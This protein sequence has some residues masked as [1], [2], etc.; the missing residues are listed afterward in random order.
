MATTDFLNALGVGS[1]FSSKEVITA[2]VDA[3]KVPTQENKQQDRSHRSQN[4]RAWCSKSELNT[5]KES[6]AKLKDATD[7]DSFSI[8][9]SQATALTVTAGAGASA[10]NHS[11]TVSSI[12]KAQTTNLT[13]SVLPFFKRFSA[14]K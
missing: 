6:A 12:A 7:F 13:Q 1:S 11:I 10:A 9:N 4:K 3:E 14:F 8:T 2:L 5:L